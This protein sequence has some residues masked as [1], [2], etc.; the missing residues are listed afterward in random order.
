[1]PQEQAG[2]EVK[3]GIHR[4]PDNWLVS[5]NVLEC[6][7][8]NEAGHPEILRGHG[9]KESGVGEE[10]PRPFEIHIIIGDEAIVERGYVGSET[11]EGE[12]KEKGSP[13]QQTVQHLGFE[14]FFEVSFQ[15]IDRDSILEHRVPV[16]NGHLAIFKGLMIDGNAKRRPD[17]ILPGITLSDVAAV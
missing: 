3:S 15:R 4:I 10:L 17:F 8:Y 6:L 11:G 9:E 2:D 1:S 12:K 16:P 7:E 13:R 14:T 5:E